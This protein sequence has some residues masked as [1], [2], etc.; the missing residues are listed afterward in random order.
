MGTIF[1]LD[2]S[3]HSGD[4]VNSGDG[5]DFKGQPFFVLA[6]VGLTDEDAVA[7]HIAELRSVHRIPP[8]ELKSKSLTAKP[9]FVAEILEYL[10][11]INAPLF[12]ELVEKRYFI[13]INMVSFHVLPP[14]MGFHPGEKLSFLQNTLADYLYAEATQEVLDAFVN[15]CLDPSDQKVRQSF[16]ELEKLAL[17]R[18]ERSDIARGLVQMLKDTLREYEEMKQ[19]G[20]EA[21]LRFLPPPDIN[22]RGKRVWMLPNL[23]SFANI[24]ARLNRYYGRKLRDIHI[25]HDQQLEVE[26]ILRQGKVVVEAQKDGGR[27]PPTPHSDYVFEEEATFAF[28]QSHDGIGLQMADIVAGA[29]MRYFRD[30]LNADVHPDLAS[31]VERLIGFSDELTGY[32]INQVVALQAVRRA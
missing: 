14:C 31:S 2:E 3:G 26:D 28:A 5:F 9:K 13:C 32:G 19:E 11:S 10:Q 29:V 4:M 20:A 24:Y 1:Y 12:V 27:L 25:V 15:A 16:S 23:T 22:K 30:S 7:T 18:R 21:F 6:A 17:S 8:T